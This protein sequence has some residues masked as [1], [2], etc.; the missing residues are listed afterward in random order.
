M[1]KYYHSLPK[2]PVYSV[3]QGTPLNNPGWIVATPH[4]RRAGGGLLRRAYSRGFRVSRREGVPLSP[5]K[6]GF[7]G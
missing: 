3:E 5:C 7:P 6:P 2:I 4:V 1:P